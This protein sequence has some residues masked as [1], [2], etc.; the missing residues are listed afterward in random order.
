MAVAERGVLPRGHSAVVTRPSK[1]YQGTQAVQHVLE[2]KVVT[3]FW[4]GLKEKDW[5][6]MPFYLLFV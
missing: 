1:E 3:E 4:F 5:H 6:G 2:V